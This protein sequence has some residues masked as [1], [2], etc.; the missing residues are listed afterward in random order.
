MNLNM[1]LF[2]YFIIM[3]FIFKKKKDM[4]NLITILSIL[5]YQNV[6]SIQLK[7]DIKR[8]ED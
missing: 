7:N 3:N 5:F 8:T 4:I 2:F 1:K 6:A